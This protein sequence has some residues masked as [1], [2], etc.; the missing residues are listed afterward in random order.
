MH[1]LPYWRLSGFYFFYFAFVGAM[2]PFWGLYLKS[3]EFN[4]FQIGVLMSLLQVMRIFAPNIWGWFA[5]HSGKR[6]AIVQ[7]A[8]SLSL[9]AY[10]GVFFGTSFLWLFAVMS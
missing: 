9:V 5:D 8:A 10:A 3:L 1:S 2:A 4:A 7:I 6:V